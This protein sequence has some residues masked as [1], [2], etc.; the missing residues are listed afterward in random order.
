MISNKAKLTAED[1][2]STAPGE[3]HKPLPDLTEKIWQELPRSHLF[4]TGQ[5]CYKVKRQIPLSAVK[6]FNFNLTVHK[7][8]IALDLDY[9]KH[10]TL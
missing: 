3:G 1:V 6:N 7:K 9:L 2:A 4:P 8:K 10:S 5:F